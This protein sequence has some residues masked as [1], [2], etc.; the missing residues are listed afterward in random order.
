MADNSF[1]SGDAKIDLTNCDREPIH[2]LG[3]VQ[4]YGCLIAVSHDWLVNHVSGNVKQLLGLE[5]EDLVGT[6]LNDHLPAETRHRLRSK[7]QLLDRNGDAAR[8]FALDVFEDGRVFDLSIHVSGRTVVFEF[9]AKSG[10]EQRDDMAYVQPLI[11]RI[12]RHRD[13]EGLCKEGARALKALT[14]FD[15]V[16]VYQFADDGTGTVVAEARE[17]SMEPYLG[18]RYPASDIPKQARELYK[19][20][21]LRLIA[22]VDGEVFPIVPANNP[23]GQPLDLSLAVTRSVSPIHLEYLRNM[24]V[25]AS[26]SVSILRKGELWGLFACHH[27]T[28]YY[29]DYEKRTAVELFAQLFSYELAEKE[30][31]LERHGRDKAQALHNRLMARLSSD[32]DPFGSFEADAAEIAQVIDFDGIALFSDGRYAALGAAPTE[33][34]FAGLARFLNTTA[35]GHVFATDRIGQ[36][37]EAAS[38]FADRA[39]GLLALPISRSPRDYI[40]LFRR[41]IAQIVTWAGD[42]AKPVDV[43]PNGIRLTPRK[44]FEA[45]QEIVKGRSAAWTRGELQAAE[46]LRVTLLEVVLKVTDEANLERKK[47]HEQQELLIAELNHRVRNILNLIRGLVSQGRGETETIE[48]FTAVLDGRIQALARAHDQLTQ[49]DWSSVSLVKLIEIELKAFTNDKQGRVSISGNDALL[50]PE[51]FSTMALVVHEL[52]TNSAKYGALSDSTGSVA[53][54]LRREASGD[55]LAEWR[56]KNGPPVKAPTRRGFGTTIIEKSVPFELKGKAD[57]RFRMT[58]VEADFVIPADYVEDATAKDREDRPQK[59]NEAPVDLTLEGAVLLV[60]DNMI[61]AMDV[62]DVLTELG[63]SDVQTASTVN[64]ALRLLESRPFE[65]AVLDVNLGKETSVAI[66]ARL[67]ELGI[68]FALATGYG[69]TDDITTAYGDAPILKK[70]YVKERLART[71]QVAMKQNEQKQNER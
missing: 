65:L 64:D 57:L 22:N 52:I 54:E 9:E 45:W 25:A 58:G 18:L 53:I 48:A 39:V 36:R 71:L 43:G 2:V 69:T 67:R 56:E 11:A 17:R 20:S 34:E 61:I 32:A 30:N 47:A 59:T 23:E 66:A 6:S 51:A 38:A 26:M 4:S 19:R 3:Q 60:E 31:D 33:Q 12:R 24:G 27:E 7:L 37:Y 44:S 29:V 1:L 15:R 28:P 5:A 62:S 70:P 55:L 63:A 14:G 40:V 42:P 46:A 68:P 16:M 13:L 10:S 41:E 8:I 21:L 49:K 50:T 35:T